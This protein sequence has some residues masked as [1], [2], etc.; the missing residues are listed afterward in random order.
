MA[1]FKGCF[2]KIGARLVF[3]LG[4]NDAMFWRTGVVYT[5]GRFLR[6]SS[7]MFIRFGVSIFLSHGLINDLGLWELVILQS[8]F[9]TKIP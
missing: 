8:W 5:I 3:C 4:K 9:D 6:I 1:N 2:G 7:D